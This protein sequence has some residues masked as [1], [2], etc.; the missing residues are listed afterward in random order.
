MLYLPGTMFLESERLIRHKMKYELFEYVNRIYLKWD[1]NPLKA[2]F[3]QKS[4]CFVLNPDPDGKFIWSFRGSLN[5]CGASQQNSVAAK[6]RRSV[7]PN[8]WSGWGLVKLLHTAHPS[9]HKPRDLRL[10]EREKTYILFKAENFTMAA[11]LKVLA[12]T[13]AEEE[14]GSCARM[15]ITSVQITLG[16]HDFRLSWFDWTVKFIPLTSDLLTQLASS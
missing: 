4:S 5:N 15:L 8:N 3:T 13:A 9:L 1:N 6:Q 10:F 7:P 14:G 12:C 11:E 2:Q 16:S